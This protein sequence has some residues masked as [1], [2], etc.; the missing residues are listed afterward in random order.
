MPIPVPTPLAT[1]TATL[2]PQ[3][4]SLV[5][6]SAL[7]TAPTT[8]INPRTNRQLIEDLMAYNATDLAPDIASCGTGK[9]GAC[10]TRS[11]SKKAADRAAEE[12]A[13]LF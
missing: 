12:F 1:P 13:K 4:E 7:A 9:E 6:C 3:P 2:V 5:K 10:T 8:T 11:A